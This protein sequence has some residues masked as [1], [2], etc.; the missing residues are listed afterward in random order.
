M[1][2]YPNK[3]TPTKSPPAVMWFKVYTGLMALMYIV[4]FIG[5]GV[6]V[7]LADKAGEPERMELLTNGI[8]LAVVGLPFAIACALPFFFPRK[9]WVW[10]YNLVIITIGMTSCCCLP[11]CVP[12]LIFWLKPEIKIW[13]GRNI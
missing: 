11:A 4:F 12:L 2:S 5:G 13:Y 3:L 8:V 7:F 6:M 10:I 9:P 1:D